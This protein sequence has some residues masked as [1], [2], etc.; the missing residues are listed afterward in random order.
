VLAGRLRVGRILN[1]S[2]PAVPA[3]QRFYAGGGGSV[4]GFA[5]QAV[6]DRL[7]DGTPRGGLSLF[8][9]SAEVRHDLS[10]TWGVAAFVDTGAIGSTGPV[11]FKNLAVGAGVGVRYTVG[12]IPI[13]VDIATPV[14]NGKDQGAFQIY[15]SIGQS[16]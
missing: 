1:G 11:D 3:S 2:I 8:E 7:A 10:R 14:A 15:I 5:Y 12:V 13:R 6:G 16:F 4:R 9:A